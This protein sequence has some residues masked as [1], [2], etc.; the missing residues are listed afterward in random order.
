MLKIEFSKIEQII[1]NSLIQKLIYCTETLSILSIQ[2][3]EDMLDPLS[4][5]TQMF[6]KRRL[7]C[8]EFNK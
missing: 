1:L 3:K 8:V 2:S 4:V 5:L 6:T 7:E